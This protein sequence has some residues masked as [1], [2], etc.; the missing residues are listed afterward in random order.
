MVHHPRGLGLEIA[1]AALDAGDQ[2]VATGRDAGKIEASFGG[3]ADHLLAVTLDV[4]DT[5]SI[6]VA[7]D[8]AFQRFGRIDVL[9]N[10]AGYGLLGAFE[11]L[12]PESIDRQFARPMSQR[13][14]PADFGLGR[15]AR[16]LRFGADPP[17]GP[18]R[19]YIPTTTA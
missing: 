8:A 4:T 13:I 15:P 2:I 17:G 3:H 14:S 9:V 7:V 16:R 19:S 10:N 11:E 1:R 6:Q 5:S 18:T 12:S